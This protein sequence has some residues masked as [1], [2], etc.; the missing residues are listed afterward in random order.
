M[1]AR[2]WIGVGAN[3]GNRLETMRSAIAMIPVN[4]AATKVVAA[5]PVYETRPVGPSKELFLN[6]VVE[7][8]TS[9]SPRE[10]LEGLH[11][12]ERA[13]QRERRIRWEARTLDLDLLAYCPDDGRE[14]VRHDDGDLM[15]PHPR[16]H[17]RDFVLRPLVDLG[18]A[19]ALHEGRTPAQLLEGIPAD[20]LTIVRQTPDGL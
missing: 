17:L 4:V 11:A 16:A 14:I 1:T 20:A 9:A 13:H 12:I 6:A 19:I 7:V 2:A 5:S 10:L 18:A 8:L 15:Q 3:L